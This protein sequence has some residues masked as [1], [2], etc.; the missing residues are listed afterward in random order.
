[1]RKNIIYIGIIL[2]MTVLVSVMC[3]SYAFFTHKIEDHGKLN[4]VAGTL[5]YKLENNKL[6]NNN[7]ITVPSGLTQR[8]D[9][10][11]ISLNDIDS[12][13]ELYYITNNNDIE[14]NYT[15]TSID[16]PTGTIEAKSSKTVSIRIN[17]KSEEDATITFSVAGG[18]INNSLV[19]NE[20]NHINALCDNETTFCIST[21]EQLITLANEVNSGDNKAGKTYYLEN[22]LDLGGKF[23]SE[24][25]MLEGSTNWTP[26]GD[27]A[28]SI[29]FSGTFDGDGHVIRKLYINSS[30]TYPALF[31]YI[32]NGTIRKL[33]IE[34]SYIKSG[35]DKSANSIVRVLSKSTMELC[36]NKATV[37]GGKS[38]AGLVAMISSGSVVKNCY[39]GGNIT[40]TTQFTAGLVGYSSDGTIK[41]SYNYGVVNGSGR[42]SGGICGGNAGTITDTYNIGNVTSSE[43]G[44]GI[45]GQLYKNGKIN[46]SYNSGIISLNCGGIIGTIGNHPGEELFNNFYLNTTSK[47][48]IYMSYNSDYESKSDN[49]TTPLSESEMPSILSVVNNDN[50]FTEDTLN[51]NNGNPVL[52][53]ELQY[54]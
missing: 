26:I 36:Y 45:S 21:K 31:G 24:G 28:T 14:V 8:I 32:Y 53:W 46:N 25:N 44:G 41:N 35:S 18:F 11:I 54:K 5:N 39:N 9:L 47:Y 48:G 42:E 52:K 50:A 15:S 17:N 6:E 1:M 34:D 38:S 33:G 12:K 13:Y 40:G 7:S 30:E 51:I 29:A 19:L 37:D 2:I 16:N 43:A 3:F 27:Y 20:I 22:D 4:I 49:E 23:D 10:K